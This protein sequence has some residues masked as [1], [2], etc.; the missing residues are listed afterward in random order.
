MGIRPLTPRYSR[1]ESAAVGIVSYDMQVTLTCAASIEFC[2]TGIV[3]VS[4]DENAEGVLARIV[5]KH[6]V[7]FDHL[8]HVRASARAIPPLQRCGK[9]G[10]YLLTSPKRGR[11]R[12]S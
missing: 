11:R 2:R 1:G 12:T 5:G 6:N 10:H 3:A 4:D 8:P 7:L 9:E